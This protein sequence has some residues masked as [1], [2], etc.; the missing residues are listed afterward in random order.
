MELSGA[1]S[2]PQVRLETPRLAALKDKLH[3]RA[4]PQPEPFPNKRSLPRTTVPVAKT[5][6][7]VLEQAGDPMSVQRIHRACEQLIGRPVVYGTV[8]DWLSDN[9]KT[10][11]V[12]RVKHG[13]YR[14]ASPSQPGRA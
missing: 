10:N 11:K 9:A 3:T 2:N 12:T 4:S 8:R 1:F 13:I 7:H 14:L 6:I 5:I